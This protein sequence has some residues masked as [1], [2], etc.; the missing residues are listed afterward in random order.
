MLSKA[1]Y[2]INFIDKGICILLGLNRD[3]K[4]SPNLVRF[5]KGRLFISST[6]SYKRTPLIVDWETYRKQDLPYITSQD[7]LKLGAAIGESLAKDLTVSF[8]EP[9]INKEI[10]YE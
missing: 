1:L 3:V 6:E 4:T 2:V 10:N 7:R 9:L 8:E 5:S